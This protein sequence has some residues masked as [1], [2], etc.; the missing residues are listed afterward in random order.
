MIKWIPVAEA[1]KIPGRELIGISIDRNSDPF[2]TFW[3]P[4]LNR[5]YCTP[6][7]VIEMPEFPQEKSDDSRKINK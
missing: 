2:F 5:F 4:T 1:P 7:H 3:S 6:T